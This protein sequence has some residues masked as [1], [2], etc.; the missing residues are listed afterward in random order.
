MGLMACDTR[1]RSIRGRS[2]SGNDMHRE[3][4]SQLPE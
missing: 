2:D 1:I 3:Q 4:I